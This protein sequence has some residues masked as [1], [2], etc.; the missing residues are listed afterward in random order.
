M[1]KLIMTN[2][3]RATISAL[4]FGA[5]TFGYAQTATP[6]DSTKV[7]TTQT[8]TAQSPEIA[9][10]KAKIAAN[11]NDTESLVNLAT[12]YQNAKD[13][14]G[15][16]A[17]WKNISTLLP[18]WAP[19]YYSQ[20]YVYQSMKDDANAKTAY[21]KYISTV[22]PEEIEASKKNLAYAE[23]FVAYSYKDSDKEK[24]KQHIA[25]SLEYDPMNADAMKLK[26]FLNS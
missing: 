13:L 6:S 21:E 22:K 5:I 20:G 25:K 7:Q 23:F 11:P 2:T 8:Q 15:A 16:L 24:A 18:D 1:K 17:T 10:L 3:K 26:T 9:A 12:A 19:G 4:F 14:P